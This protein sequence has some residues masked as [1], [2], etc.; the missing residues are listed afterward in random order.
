MAKSTRIDNYPA[1]WEL[2]LKEHSKPSTRRLHTVGILTAVV[3]LCYF[4]AE[5]KFHLIPWALVAG[6]AISWAS[7]FFVEKNKP[8]SWKYPLWSFVSDFRMAFGVLTGTR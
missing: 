7:H 8:L 5:Y 2:Y 3:L 6:Y 1:F 4:I